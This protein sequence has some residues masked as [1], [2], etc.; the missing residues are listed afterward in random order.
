MWPDKKGMTLSVQQRAEIQATPGADD[1]QSPSSFAR[2]FESTLRVQEQQQRVR[3]DLALF[4]DDHIYA[5]CSADVLFLGRWLARE[6][7][8]TKDDAPCI[9]QQQLEK[10]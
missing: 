2:R 7:G 6:D 1:F 3:V 8:R 4:V 5:A 9:V 10:R